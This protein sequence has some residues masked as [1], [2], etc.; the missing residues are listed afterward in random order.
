MTVS[1]VNKPVSV[2]VLLRE[3]GTSRPVAFVWRGQRL[4]IESW[5]REGTKTS[6]GRSLRC[7]LVQTAGHQTWELCQDIETAQWVIARRWS[8]QAATA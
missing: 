3:D 7:F 2:E 8:A 1:F 5:G 4:Q 6:H